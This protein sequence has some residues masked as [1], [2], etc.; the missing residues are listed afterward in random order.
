MLPAPALPTYQRDV[1]DDGS[2]SDSGNDAMGPPPSYASRRSRSRSCG[3]RGGRS[4]RG[5]R[6]TSPSGL[7]YRRGAYAGRHKPG[8]YGANK[9][10]KYCAGCQQYQKFDCFALNQRF[11][12]VCKRRLDSI[13]KQ[14]RSQGQLEW[15]ANVKED[16]APRKSTRC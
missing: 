6:S 10:M 9:G 2:G 16:P 11:C 13:W 3:G 7:A 15:F 5:G 12:Q 14:A 4:S 1:I 8:P